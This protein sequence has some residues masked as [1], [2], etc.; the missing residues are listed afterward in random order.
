MK[1]SK[2]QNKDQNMHAALNGGAETYQQNHQE[3]D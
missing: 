2:I 3:T 1:R